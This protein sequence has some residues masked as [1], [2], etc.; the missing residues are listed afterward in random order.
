MMNPTTLEGPLAA[1]REAEVDLLTDIATALADVGDATEADRKRLSDVAQDLREMFFLVSIIGEF[2]AGK[3]TFVNALLGEQLLPTGITPTTEVIELVRYSETADR[4]PTMRGMSLREWSHPNTGAEG[5]AIVDTPGTGSVFKQHETVAKD[6]L[7]RSDLVIFLLSAKRAF[8]ET[9][10]IYMETAKN[11]GKK[12]ILVVNQV[13]LLEPAEQTQVRRFIE[14]QVK[15]HLNLQPLLFMVSAKDALASGGDSG[16]MDAVKAHLRGVFA[17]M[18]PAKQKLLAQLDMAQS[19]VQTYYDTVR[20]SAELV[21][22]DTSKV[23]EVQQELQSQ[24]LGLDTQLKEARAEVDKVF[25]GMR[26]RGLNFINTN[27]SVR[28]VASSVNR[29]KLQAEFQDVV[30]GRALRDVNDAAGGYVN[31]VIDHSRLYWRGVIERLNQ[32][33][34]LLD[35]EFSGGLDADVYAE[36]RE[37]LQDAIR[38]AEAELKTYS[39]GR[40]VND[41]HEAFETNASG[42]RVASVA[43]VGG[44]IGAIVALA[45]PGPL[46][47][48]GA[49]ALALPAF[50]VAAPLAVGGGWYALRYYRRI[51]AETK[52]EFNQRV[53]YLMESYHTALN[54]LTK[55]ERDRLTQYGNQVLTPIFSRLEVLAKRYSDQELKLQN[56]KKRIETLRSG[57]EGV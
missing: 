52:R 12:L 1:L 43:A 15:E 27:L 54:D 46:V 37:S 11:Y 55:K 31:A 57:I 30:I 41:L 42:F 20:R 6:F 9:E 13:D 10:R 3:S 17:E 18:P 36:Q 34:E 38:I 40:V 50:V 35:Q 4:K 45:T 39:S 16:G 2:N 14:Q 51:T 32:L 23:R 24:S 8:A 29:E 56:F 44:L 33:Q 22:A 48:V 21:S 7:H 28:K 26:Q 5:V 49:A 53:D 47:G 19:V 25:L